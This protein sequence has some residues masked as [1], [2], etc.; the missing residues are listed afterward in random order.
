MRGEIVKREGRDTIRLQQILLKREYILQLDKTLCV[1]CGVCQTV[2]PK[3]AIELQPGELSEGRLMKRPTIEFDVDS[4]IL[5]GECVVLCPLNALRM[6]VD[7]E[8]ITTIQ[9]NQAFPWLLKEITVTLEGCDVECGLKCQE[10]CPT[11][12]IEVL[13]EKTETGQILKIKEVKIEETHCLYCGICQTACPTEALQVKKP[14]KGNIHLN[15][16]LCPEGCRACVDICPSHALQPGEE[17]KPEA[18][19]EACIYCFACQQICPEKAI[20]I[21]I[22]QV[23]HTPIRSAAWLTALEKLTSSKVVRKELET[24][25]GTKRYTLVKERQSIPH[26]H[27]HEASKQY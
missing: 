25:S 5:C 4:C 20:K 23:N 8:N 18:T 21:R 15:V 2:C 13:T 27:P 11:E 6:V 3:D 16:D 1:G 10:E 12:A 24:K 9:K 22:D 7:G 14:F 26:I 17:G 19:L